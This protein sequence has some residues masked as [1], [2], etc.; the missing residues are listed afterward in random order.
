MS[1]GPL[2]GYGLTQVETRDFEPLPMVPL[3][4]TTDERLARIRSV[5][6]DT[7]SPRSSYYKCF[8]IVNGE[9]THTLK[10]LDSRWVVIAIILIYNRYTAHNVILEMYIIRCCW[11]TSSIIHDLQK[12]TP[13][14]LLLQSSFF[15]SFCL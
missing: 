2:F 14:L 8:I 6:G 7:R 4:E 3:V 12:Q 10:V 1:R 13:V 11:D 5:V 9:L 15:R